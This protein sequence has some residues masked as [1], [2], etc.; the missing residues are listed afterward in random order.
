MAFLDEPFTSRVFDPQLTWFNAPPE[1]EIGDEG[2]TVATRAES[3]FWQRTHYGFQRDDGHALLA[4]VSGDF[5]IETA[6]SFSPVHRYDQAG[7]LI[8][9]SADCWLKTSIEFELDEPSRLGS[10]VT[11]HGWSDWATQNVAPTV[12]AARYRVTRKAGDYLIEHAPPTGEYSQ[13]RIARLHSDDGRS[14][15]RAGLYACSPQ[16]PGFRASFRYLRLGE[17]NGG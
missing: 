6:V 16:G 5:Q 1:F 13:L 14:P 17:V 11:N 12:R 15:V 2:L 8:R 7:L 9:I 4:E 10:V 3:D